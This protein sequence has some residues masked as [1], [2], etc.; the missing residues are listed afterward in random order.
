MAK[1]GRT[2]EARNLLDKLLKLSSERFIPYSHIALIYNGLGER[3]KTFEWLEKGYEQHDPKM[4]FLKVEPK[5]NNLR[6]DSRFQ[7]LLR[8]VGFPADEN[9]PGRITGE[10]DETRTAQNF[11]L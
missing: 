1:S 5:W 2:D 3:D 6:S 11:L 8:R 10:V 9:A 4:A 7:D